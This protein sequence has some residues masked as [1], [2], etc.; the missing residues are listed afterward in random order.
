MIAHLSG[1]ARSHEN[2][3][4]IRARPAFLMTVDTEADDLW[5]R[6]RTVTTHNA[7][8]LPRFQALCEAYGLKPTYLVSYEMAGDPAFQA[9]ARHLVC[10]GTA[11][12]GM[13]LHAWIT[14]PAVPLTDDDAAFQPYL[15]EYPPEVMERKIAAATARLEE[16]FGV[17]ML[18]HRAGR[19]GFD[20]VYA[21]M[22]VR[23]G[24]RVDCSVTPGVSWRRH[25]G[26]P[27]GGGGPDYTRF[28]AE[29]YFV[30]L[31]DVS[32]PGDSWLLEVPVTVIRTPPA[33]LTALAH[34]AAWGPRAGAVAERLW[35]T[36]RWLRPNGRNG[37]EL[38]QIVRDAARA[39]RSFV[40][41]ML[42]SSELMPGGSPR[43]R[44]PGSIERLYGDLEALFAAARE[45]CRPA[46]LAEFYDAAAA[47]RTGLYPD[48]AK[49]AW[50]DRCRIESASFS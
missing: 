11:E 39:G 7:R 50:S 34:R 25:R 4:G 37:A 44:T 45:C 14:P 1:E 9:F 33:G 40:E 15:T 5:S 29:A 30:D 36:V 27:A 35:P 42:H 2:G 23:F 38:I 22:L 46:T 48:A 13:H 20:A 49:P 3:A 21:R 10:Q 43:F 18:S 47:N 28:P 41:F 24:Y 12:I 6:P 19:W 26:H 32:R 17:K 31:D 8:Y 16:T